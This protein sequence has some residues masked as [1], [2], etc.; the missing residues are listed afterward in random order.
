[1]GE[2]DDNKIKFTSQS[3]IEK[4]EKQAQTV[5]KQNVERVIKAVQSGYDID[6]F[7]FGLKVK[8][9]MPELWKKIKP[10]W[11]DLFK[12]VQVKANAEVRIKHAGLLSN[13]IMMG[14]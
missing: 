9:D 1:M 12:N 13:P 8:Q 5:L 2:I 7:G 3:E 14:D 11:D 4:L 10:D 6:I